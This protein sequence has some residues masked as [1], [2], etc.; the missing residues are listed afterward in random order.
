MVLL[1]TRDVSCDAASEMRALDGR[2][3]AGVVMSSFV[4]CVWRL[5]VTAMCQFVF[6]MAG[7]VCVDVCSCVVWY[8]SGMYDFVVLVPVPVVVFVLTR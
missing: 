5:Y 8:H 3:R 7:Y 6:I 2:R 1:G 4:M